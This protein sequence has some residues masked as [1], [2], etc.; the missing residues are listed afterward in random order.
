MAAIEPTFRQTIAI[1]G[2]I[3][4]AP[5][6]YKHAVPAD[7]PAAPDFPDSLNSYEQAEVNAWLEKKKENTDLTTPTLPD[8]IA[9]INEYITF[10]SQ[11]DA[12]TVSDRLGRETQWRW[13]WA[14][15]M[16]HTEATVAPSSTDDGVSSN[17]PPRVNAYVP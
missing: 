5:L 15:S 2:N 17:P 8:A 6:W 1:Y 14:D 13:S 7:Y 10:Y 12:W 11:L 4:E 9:K 16:L 3:P